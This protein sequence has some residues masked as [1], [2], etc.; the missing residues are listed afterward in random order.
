V[1]TRLKPRDQGDLGEVAAMAWLTKV[2]ARVSVPLL[3]SPDYDLIAELNGELVRVQV[4]TCTLRRGDRFQVQLATCGGNQSWTGIVKRFDPSRC[5][6]LFV[7]VGDGRRWLVPSRAV[8]GR[9]SIV[10]G[11]SK[12]SEFEVDP[13][14]APAFAI[15]GASRIGRRRGS[16]DVGESGR[17]VNSVPQA[18]WVRIPPPP[19]RPTPGDDASASGT[20]ADRERRARTR[21]SPGHQITIPIAP[22][23][24]ARLRA[25]DRLRVDADGAGR[26]VLTRIEELIAR[27]SSLLPVAR[28]PASEPDPSYKPYARED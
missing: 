15:D 12:Y 23:R 9:H 13:E 18:E 3:H 5:D 10:V 26:V 2:G 16:A 22:F 6:F 27:Q 20:D 19:S 8:E 14:Y 24:A 7:L 11:G 4:K 21:I 28:D 25:G 1:T 17:T